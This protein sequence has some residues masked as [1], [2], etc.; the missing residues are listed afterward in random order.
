MKPERVELR[1]GRVVWH[2]GGAPDAQA[3]AAAVQAA[4]QRALAQQQAP[5]AASALGHAGDAV[6]RHVMPRLAQEQR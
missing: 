4:L 5:A 6:A 2:G 3:L 1:I